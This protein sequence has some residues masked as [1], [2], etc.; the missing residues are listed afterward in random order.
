[1]SATNGSDDFKAPKEIFRFDDFELDRGTYELRRAGL[2]VPLQRLPFEL[3]YL[4]IECRGQLVTRQ[5]IIERLWGKSVFVD[6]ENGINTAVNKIRRALNDDADEPRFVVTVPAK[7]YR[8]VAAVSLPNGESSGLPLSEN[9]INGDELGTAELP[10]EADEVDARIGSEKRPVGKKY[11]RNVLLSVGLVLMVAVAVLAPHFGLRPPASPALPLPDQ[12]SIAVLPFTNMS[13]DREQEYFSDGITDDLITALSRIPNLFVIARTSTFTY[14]GKAAK[15][16]EVSRELG[17]KYIL[18]GSVHKAGDQVRIMAQL[19]DATTGAQLWAER[20]DRPIRDI[21][22]LQDE[23]VQRIV[24]T[25]NLQLA[26]S[27]RGILIT[28]RTDNLEAYDYFLRGVEFFTFGSPTKEPFDKARQMF[29]KAIEFDPKYSDA[30]AELGSVLVAGQTSQWNHDPDGVDRAIEL[31]QRSIALDNSNAFAYA[32]MSFA[33]TLKRQYD[34]GITDAERALAF[35]PNSKD[36]YA[37]MA[38]ALAYSGRPAEA[39]VAAQKAM[40]LDPRHRDLHSLFEGMAYMLM[41]SYELAIPLVK[42]YLA[43]YPNFI[44]GHLDLIVCYVELGRNEEARAEAVE[45]MR[46]NPEFS[47]AAQKRISP[48]KEPLRE[49]NYGDMAKAGLK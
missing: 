9:S 44:P 45:V 39:L 2:S 25:L 47:L 31:E 22:A 15:V 5:Q 46:I 17:V 30:Y 19:V 32:I 20:Y 34:L 1:M 16:Q 24:T 28:K 33:H 11:W 8:F 27:E 26:V 10:T 36:G 42:T 6:S 14:K 7:G 35:D 49:R 37:S 4:L 18:E 48:L 41:G 29:Q 3:L 40:R 43:S 12:P 23:I 38:N 21:F 13:G